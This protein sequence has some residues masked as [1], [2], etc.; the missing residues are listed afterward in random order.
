MKRKAP[1][2]GTLDNTV[3]D[4]P[5]VL[6]ADKAA[7]K[8]REDEIMR[9]RWAA[10][11][12]EFQLVRQLARHIQSSPALLRLRGFQLHAV[13]IVGNNEIEPHVNDAGFENHRGPGEPQ[14]FPDPQSR[15]RWHHDES[16]I[17]APLLRCHYELF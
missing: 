1:Y 2:L 17:E 16:A 14:N 15:Q 10:K 11:F 9:A 3:K 13:L 7:G 12:P 6:P 8:R 5:G 4:I